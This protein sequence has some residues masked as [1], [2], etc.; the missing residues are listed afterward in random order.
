DGATTTSAPV[1]VTVEAPAGPVNPYERVE[2]ESFHSMQGVQIVTAGTGQAVGYI[3]NG[4]WIRFNDVEFGT[5]GAYSV[6]ASVASGGIGGTIEFRLNSTT[7]T[8]VGSMTV[9]VTGGWNNY[10][11]RTANISG[12]TGTNDL[13]LVFK[14]GASALFDI[15]HFEFEE[16]APGGGTLEVAGELRKWHKITFTGEGPQTSE[17]DSN[18]PFLNYRFN[19]NLVSPS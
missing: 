19:L 11:T 12:A 10:I 13:Y 14:G 1:T 16:G 3:D 5:L 17:L 6:T 2:A 9:P 8:L 15:D 18:N 7:G 4:D